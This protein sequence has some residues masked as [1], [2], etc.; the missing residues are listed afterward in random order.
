MVCLELPV[1]KTALG[2]I[3]KYTGKKF[4]YENKNYR[5]AAF[6]QYISWIYTRLGRNIRQVIPACIVWE[7]RKKFPSDDG[8]YVPF[9]YSEV[10]EEV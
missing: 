6:K 9:K 7:I 5:F 1:L 3:T 2:T 8:E 10:S 4:D